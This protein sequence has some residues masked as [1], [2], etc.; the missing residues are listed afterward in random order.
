[1][2]RKEKIIYIA[3]V[4][5]SDGFITVIKN[6]AR[7]RPNY[8]TNLGI[9]QREEQAV[10]LAH[11]LFG[12]TLRYQDFSGYERFSPTPM[13]QWILSGEKLTK[14]LP[15]LIPYLLIK[16]DRAILSLKL[17]E[18][19]NRWRK[20]NPTP[21][22]VYEERKSIYEEAKRLNQYRAVAET[23]SN[24]LT[25]MLVCDSPNCKDSKLAELSRND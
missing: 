18:S 8:F 20:F 17:R 6:M 7:R 14:A 16:R 25:E 10:M 13:W 22:K 9:S 21:V 2:S 12:G 15:Q 24:G 3:G 11:N 5:D 19:I 23:K 4:I 1:M